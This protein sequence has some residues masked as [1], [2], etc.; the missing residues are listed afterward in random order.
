MSCKARTHF[1]QCVI[2]HNDFIVNV[3]WNDIDSLQQGK[4]FRFCAAKANMSNIVFMFLNLKPNICKKRSLDKWWTKE[5]NMH[6]TL[7]PTSRDFEV[8]TSGIHVVF[9]QVLQ[10]NTF[11]LCK[12]IWVSWEFQFPNSIAIVSIVWSVVSVES[13]WI[14]NSVIICNCPKVSVVFTCG[15]CHQF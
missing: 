2:L 4:V 3:N 9:L 7:W 1:L 6:P 8:K 14:C 13:S 15:H 5:W 10:K 12:K 11:D